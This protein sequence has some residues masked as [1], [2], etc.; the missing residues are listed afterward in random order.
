MYIYITCL[1]AHI[2]NIMVRLCLCWLKNLGDDVQRGYT[3]RQRSKNSASEERLQHV[4]WPTE[5]KT[6]ENMQAVC[7]HVHKRLLQ[8]R[9]K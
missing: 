4:V 2:Q 1:L 9:R 8:R 6:G 5:E 7:K 3:R